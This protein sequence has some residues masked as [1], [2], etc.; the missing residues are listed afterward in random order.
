MYGIL[1]GFK[2]NFL[3]GAPPQSSTSLT[4]SV[5]HDDHTILKTPVLDQSLKHICK[6]V[7]GR[8]SIWM[9]DSQFYRLF[10]IFFQDFLHPSNGNFFYQCHPDSNK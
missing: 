1:A 6:A 8:D 4:T 5:V 3:R 10:F 7:L 2:V 9:G